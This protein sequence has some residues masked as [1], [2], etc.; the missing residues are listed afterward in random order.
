M[1]RMTLILLLSVT[2]PIF[3]ENKY[4]VRPGDNIVDIAR[5]NLKDPSKWR[6]LLEHNGLSRPSQIKPGMVLIIPDSLKKADSQQNRKA[7]AAV[8]FMSGEV[9][10]KKSDK[11]L[12]WSSANK[13][14]R[15]Y[16]N[17]IIRTM[18]GSSAE[19]SF[20]DKPST[21][22]LIRENSIIKIKQEKVRGI[23]LSFGNLFI[24]TMKTNLKNVKFFIHSQTSVAA[25]RGTAFGVQRDKQQVDRFR[26]L[27][28]ELAVS[29]QGKTVYVKGGYATIVEKGRP[30]KKPFKLLGA[31]KTKPLEE[32]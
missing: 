20:F 29:A 16:A 10:Y 17:Y 9:K 26:C 22:I 25:I 19:I 21:T 11:I 3:A 30:P 12:G 28:G 4:K 6:K 24:K 8:I 27:T 23:D 13:G 7:I 18:T 32:K 1:K 14:L 2:L 15:L 31:I 5:E